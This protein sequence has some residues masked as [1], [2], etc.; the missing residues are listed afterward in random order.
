MVQCGVRIK[1]DCYIVTVIGRLL[2]E[3]CDIASA[4]SALA[5][6]A[7]KKLWRQL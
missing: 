3:K 2:V 7:A 4:F 5:R 6:A 1:R